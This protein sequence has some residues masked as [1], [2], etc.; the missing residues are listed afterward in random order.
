MITKEEYR[1]ALIDG[2]CFIVTQNNAE[3]KFRVYYTKD[4]SGPIPIDGLGGYWSKRMYCYHCSAIGTSRVLEITLSIGY[5]LGLTF[6][7][8]PQRMRVL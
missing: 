6:H 2:R 5:E 8:I 3:T 4:N 7:E 1:Q